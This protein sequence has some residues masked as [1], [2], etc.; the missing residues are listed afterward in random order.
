MSPPLIQSSQLLMPCDPLHL[1]HA[2]SSV[3][4]IFQLRVP[5]AL[6][7]VQ[8]SDVISAMS[9]P[10]LCRTVQHLH[11]QPGVYAVLHSCC[12]PCTHTLIRVAAWRLLRA[13]SPQRTLAVEV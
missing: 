12:T 11:W 8:L 4:H 3:V 13:L 5:Q 7:Q 6:G 2:I 10:I 9:L 1:T